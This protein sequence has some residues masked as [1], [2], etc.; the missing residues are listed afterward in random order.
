MSSKIGEKYKGVISGFSKF[1]M[2]ISLN[3]NLCQGMV[4]YR[5]MG[6]GYVK[7]NLSGSCL[8]GRQDKVLYQLGD[9]LWVRI[10]S[11]NVKRGFIDFVL[12]K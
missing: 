10:V 2:F 6:C 4:T 1:G 11:T 12:V 7:P 3:K 5:T 8:L 9:P